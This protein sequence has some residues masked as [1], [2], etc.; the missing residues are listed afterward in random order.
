MIGTAPDADIS[1]FPI[2]EPI[3]LIGNQSKAALLGLRGTLRSAVNDILSVVGATI[4]VVRVEEGTD[5]AKTWSNMVGD[6][7]LKTGVWAFTVASHRVKVKPRLIIAPGFTGHRPSH[8]VSGVVVN[9]GGAGYKTTPRIAFSDPDVTGVP[10]MVNGTV[11]AVVVTNPGIDVREVT[12]TI[13]GG[14]PDRASVVTVTM[15]ACANPVA[16]ALEAVAHRIRAHCLFE[17]PNTNNQDA[18]DYR[19][20]FGT[21]R[22][23]ILDPWALV[24]DRQLNDYVPRP[25]SAIAAGLQAYQDYNRGFWWTFSNV[26]LGQVGGI[27]RPMSWEID[28]PDTDANY[29]NEHEVTSIIRVDSQ[30]AGGYRFWGV[31]TTSDD[32]MWAFWNVSRTTDMIYESVTNAMLW[33][34]DRPISAEVI[35]QGVDSINL[36]MR[37]LQARGATLGGRAWIDKSLNTRDRL[38]AGNLRI[39]F[40]HEPPA[41]IERLTLGARRNSVY[42]DLLIDQVVKD[43]SVNRNF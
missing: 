2:N 33:I 43:L 19:Q 34:L 17:G 11:E 27:S 16:K 9:D 20:D 41:P 38:M 21:R 28:N 30:N 23:M 13:E 35:E 22:S 29:L 40:D 15:G 31:R 24:W 10:Q 26:P 12:A 36:Y 18:V 7:A 1:V 39:E 6:P 8:G 5:L 25:S 3:L 4:V 37:S 42:Y 14:N 32:P